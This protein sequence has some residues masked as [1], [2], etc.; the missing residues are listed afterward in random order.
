ML[1]QPPLHL[2]R[3]LQLAPLRLLAF[4]IKEMTGFL[5]LA[6]KASRQ[7]TRPRGRVMAC[8]R[9]GEAS[10]D[11]TMTDALIKRCLAPLAEFLVRLLF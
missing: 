5:E 2:R 7:V 10:L 3:T 8:T 6:A 1:G 9:D 4:S 11:V